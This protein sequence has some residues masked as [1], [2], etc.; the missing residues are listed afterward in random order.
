[1]S[2]SRAG[3]SSRALALGLTG[4]FAL[5]GCGGG[6]GGGD[7]DDTG[8]P[9]A[10][11]VVPPDAPAGFTVRD[12]ARA[13]AQHL[14]GDGH[15]MIGVGNDNSG[16]YDHAVPIDL[17]YAYLVGYGDDGGW[18]TWNADG[19][20]AT[21]F[22]QAA[23]QHGVTPMYTYYQLALELENGNDAALADG[24]RMHQ[25]LTDMRLLFTRIAETGAP[26]VVTLEPD[27]FG[28][29]MQRAD[30]GTP[31][32]QLVART[33]FA[34]V[35][36]CA[37]LPETAA[38]LMRCVLA[39]GHTLAPEARIGFHASQWGAWFDATDPGAD[40]EAS[41][42]A[43]GGFLRSVG[44]DAT[45]FVAVETLDR[46]AGFWETGG[47]GG[48][49]SAT[50]GPRGPVYWDADNV[51]LPNFAQ[52]L[53][54]VGA[55]TEELQRPAIWWQTPLG[56]PAATCGGAGGGSDEHWRDNR[57]RYFFD[58]VDELVDAGGAGAT[59]G[60]GAGGQTNLATDGDQL[61][62]AATA[63]QAAPFAL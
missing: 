60:T 29:L 47:G 28:Y 16:P 18:P 6:G 48:T 9:D 10:S 41:G 27:F 36:E 8:G 51:A 50:G 17:H 4:A 20:Y 49:C 40:V 52:H 19:M 15:F 1:M 44:A 11:V 5:L 2:T 56:V 34:D 25:Y 12:R 7:D 58:H 21:Y 38:G 37:G 57:V 54:W 35:P 26:A 33:Q 31:P 3:L 39:I 62:D 43:V 59:F 23:A 32:D 14:R 45:D 13:L 30:A 61:K 63:Y 42:R 46:D 22:A 24:G 53:R 55:L